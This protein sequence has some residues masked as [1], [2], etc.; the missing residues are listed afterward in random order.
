[1]ENRRRAKRARTSLR[2]YVFAYGRRVRAQIRNLSEKGALILV[3]TPLMEGT[4]IELD[5]NLKT[6][7]NPSPTSPF[8]TTGVVAFAQGLPFTKM[9]AGRYQM[10]GREVQVRADYLQNC[11]DAMNGLVAKL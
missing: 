7:S 2:G 3:D 8:Q 6:D 11:I 10:P 5:F 4:D 9:S 1:M